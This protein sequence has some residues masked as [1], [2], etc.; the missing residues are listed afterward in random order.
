MAK[1]KH[2][3]CPDPRCQ[4]VLEQYAV[5]CKALVAHQESGEKLIE[6]LVGRERQFA[7]ATANKAQADAT[8]HSKGG[9]HGQR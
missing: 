8:K 3:A 9:N 5:L 1:S 4:F 2:A 6:Y 7:K